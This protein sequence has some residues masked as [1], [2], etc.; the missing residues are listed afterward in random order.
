MSITV[1][2]GPRPPAQHGVPALSGPDWAQASATRIRSALRRALNLP[3]G[4]WFALAPSRSL[5]EGPHKLRVAGRTLVAFRDGGE[6]RIGF[7]ECPHLGASLSEGRVCDGKVVC[8]WHGLALGKAKHGAWQLL[9]SYDDGVIAWVRLDPLF[10]S[11]ALSA[12]PYMAAR[13]QVYLDAVVGMEVACDPC[14]V[15]ANRLD[16][17]H[18]AHFHPQAFAKL[19]VTEVTDEQLRVRV[20]FRLLGPLTIEVDATF[21]CPDPRTIV[22]TIVDGEGRG[23]VVETHATPL[24]PGKTLVLEATLASSPRSGFHHALVLSRA[25]RPLIARTARGLWVED[26]AYCE[27]LYALRSGALTTSIPIAVSSELTELKPRK[28]LSA[29]LR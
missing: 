5:G 1:P 22:M 9:P 17:W 14:D 28:S 10:R 24:S 26:A 19:K 13:P 15:L 8:P 16:P 11:D 4:G 25:I 29:Q 2:V 3:C 21:H 6:L 7:D 12:R 27:R 18:G 23:S 20:Q